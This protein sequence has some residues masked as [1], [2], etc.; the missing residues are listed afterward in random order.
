MHLFRVL[1]RSTHLT[2]EPLSSP[3]PTLIPF[4]YTLNYMRH[5]GLKVRC[6]YCYWLRCSTVY[7]NTNTG[8]RLTDWLAEWRKQR[9]PNWTDARECRRQTDSVYLRESSCDRLLSADECG[10]G[11]RGERDSPVLSLWHFAGYAENGE[12]GREE[13]IKHP[14]HQ[15]L[16]WIVASLIRTMFSFSQLLPLISS[17]SEW[18][19]NAI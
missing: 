14:V 16:F 3:S 10:G 9:R 8:G 7:C 18:I 5:E 15:V 6:C 12:S 13:D 4:P 2:S 11:R 17:H 1:N 19:P